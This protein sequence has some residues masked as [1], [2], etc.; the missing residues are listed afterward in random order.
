MI[1][2]ICRPLAVLIILFAICRGAAQ[3]QQVRIYL[4]A[5]APKTV[6]RHDEQGGPCAPDDYADVPV[7]RSW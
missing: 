7:R 5:P 2:H 1:H 4:A 3:A 6:W